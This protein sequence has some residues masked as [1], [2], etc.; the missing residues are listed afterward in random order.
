VTD[1]RVS[2][3]TVRF[4][5]VTAV[6]G[7]SLL[8]PGGS[9]TGL[10]GANGA[11]KTT[12]FNACAG[13]VRPTAGQVHLDGRR[14]DHLGPSRR[15]GLGLGRTFQRLA[16]FDTL[17]VEDNVRLGLEARLAGGSFRTQLWSGRGG[18]SR[19]AEAARSAMADCG[20]VDLASLPAGSLPTG[21][22]RL[23]ELARVIAGGF[24]FLLLDEPS[25][26]LDE[27][28]TARVSDVL[29]RLAS[30]G[31]GILLV[32]HDLGVVRRVCDTVHVLDFGKLLLSGPVEDVLASDAVR[33]AYVGTA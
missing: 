16:L 17:T 30:A 6:D 20:I 1:L 9:I 33:T 21:Q 15:A 28:E 3:L 2:D 8:A 12:T 24:D 5:G 10:I 26:G 18:R 14:I 31:R 29:L 22:Q 23:V 11:G 19:I 13:T 27:V 4:G 7:V 25:S 32:E